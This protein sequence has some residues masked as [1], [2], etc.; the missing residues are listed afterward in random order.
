MDKLARAI[1]MSEELTK[2]L[3]DIYN[4]D[5]SCISSTCV[6]STI[7]KNKRVLTDPAIKKENPR[8]VTFWSAYPSSRRVDK[9]RNEAKFSSLVEADQLK[10]VEAIGCH[11][12][13]WK[14]QNLDAKR[15]V[16]SQQYV[17]L[18]ST[19]INQRRWEQELPGFSKP[20]AV[21]E[22]QRQ[23]FLTSLI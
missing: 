21:S 1:K 15:D 12:S 23:Q 2:L 14:Q 8:F 11:V 22:E 3:R 7:E 4:K 20:K 10:A 13:Y 5:I 19:W 16:N 18:V 6:C 9:Q 17:P